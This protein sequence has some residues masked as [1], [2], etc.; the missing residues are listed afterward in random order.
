MMAYQVTDHKIF[1]QKIKMLEQI[2]EIA[3][4][5]GLSHDFAEAILEETNRVA[6]AYMGIDIP[7]NTQEEE[8]GEL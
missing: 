4:K 7:N 3:D 5:Q 2:Q 6:A 8:H 1:N